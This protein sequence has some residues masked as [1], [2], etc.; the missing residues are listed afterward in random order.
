MFLSASCRNIFRHASKAIFCRPFRHQVW[1]LHASQTH[2]WMEGWVPCNMEPNAFRT[3]DALRCRP[4]LPAD[5]LFVMARHE[6]E[7]WSGPDTC[8]EE[9]PSRVLSRLACI[10]GHYFSNNIQVTLSSFCSQA[11][12]KNMAPVQ[13]SEPLDVPHWVIRMYCCHAPSKRDC[14]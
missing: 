1:K 2:H 12:G 11:I 7:V 9:D 10:H 8:Q 4:K 14:F 5:R 3:V 13:G 6:H